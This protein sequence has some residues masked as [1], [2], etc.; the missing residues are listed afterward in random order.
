MRAVTQRLS[1]T[2]SKNVGHVAPY[3]AGALRDCKDVLSSPQN[4]V[5][6][7]EGSETAVL[8]HKFKSQISA[9]LQDKAVEAR[10]AAVVLIKATIELG[11]WEILR[12]CGAWVRG[13]LGLLSVRECLI[14]RKRVLPS[15]CNEPIFSPAP[16][17]LY[18]L[19]RNGQSIVGTDEICNF[20]DFSTD[21]PANTEARLYVYEEVGHNNVDENFSPYA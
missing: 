3:L 12:G 19:Q 14:W 17:L 9:L 4:H 18:L 11:G 8:V 1:A 6:G 20:H 16:W 2:L 15:S 7:K 10:W 5:M 21:L 13:L